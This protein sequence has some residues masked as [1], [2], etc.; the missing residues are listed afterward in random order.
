[1]S[2]VVGRSEEAEEATVHPV[3][4]PGPP[5][6]PREVHCAEQ[7]SRD[8][9]GG[10]GGRG[11]GVPPATHQ[12]SSTQLPGHRHVHSGPLREPGVGCGRAVADARVLGDQSFDLDSLAALHGAEGKLLPWVLS[13]Q[14]QEQQP[15]HREEGAV[16]TQGSAS[17]AACPSTAPSRRLQPRTRAHLANSALLSS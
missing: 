9:L 8:D 7:A 1:M 3:V 4:S 12:L 16:C 15:I 11:A 14:L 17:T 10:T 6:P 5:P 2:G 13:C